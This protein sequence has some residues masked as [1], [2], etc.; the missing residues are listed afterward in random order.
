MSPRRTESA[1]SSDDR[2]DQKSCSACWSPTIVSGSPSMS[3]CQQRLPPPSDSHDHAT[4]YA[5]TSARTRPLSRRFA[6]NRGFSGFNFGSVVGILH[7][8]ASGKGP[9]APTAYAVGPLFLPTRPT[10][11]KVLEW[12]R[13]HLVCTVVSGLC[14]LEGHGRTTSAGADDQLYFSHVAGRRE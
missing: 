8:L 2:F 11:I 10:K 14:L 9:D 3:G 6:G 5:H 1:P 4:R 12:P 7:S 13:S